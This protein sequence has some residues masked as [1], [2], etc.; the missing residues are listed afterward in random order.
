MG[1]RESKVRSLF[2]LSRRIS[3]AGSGLKSDQSQFVKLK[4][5]PRVIT[6]L[7]PSIGMV[8]N[9]IRLYSNFHHPPLSEGLY[10][11]AFGDN[12]HYDCS[13]LDPSAKACSNQTI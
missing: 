9:V 6:I 7:Q 5:S 10:A 11:P 12:N 4:L 2:G 8:D 1:A 13:V 3:H